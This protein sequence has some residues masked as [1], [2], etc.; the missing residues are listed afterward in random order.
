MQEHG[1]AMGGRYAEEG[2]PRG[3][4]HHYTHKGLVQA[5]ELKVM[6]GTCPESEPRVE[7]SLSYALHWGMGGWGERSE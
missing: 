5:S 1:P 7:A 2:P 6:P 3:C 4:T